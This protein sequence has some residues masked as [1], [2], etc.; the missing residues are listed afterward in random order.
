MPFLKMAWYFTILRQ[1]TTLER[2]KSF[3]KNF[4]QTFSH[5]TLTRQSGPGVCKLQGHRDNDL[6]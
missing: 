4:T 2:L 5:V 1:A 6:L 3:A